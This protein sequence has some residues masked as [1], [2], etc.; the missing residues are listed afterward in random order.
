MKDKFEEEFYRKQKEMLFQYLKNAKQIDFDVVI[1][2]VEN[3]A[4]LDGYYY[5][6][7]LEKAIDRKVPLEIF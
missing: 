2:M 3:G 6:L 7:A 1:Y 5:L 4:D